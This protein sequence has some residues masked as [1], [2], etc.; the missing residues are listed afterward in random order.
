MD[1]LQYIRACIV[2]GQRRERRNTRASVNTACPSGVELIARVADARRAG[3]MGRAGRRNNTACCS[4]VG[5]IRVVTSASYRT[6]RIGR[7]GRRNIICI[8]N[9]WCS[10]IRRWKSNITPIGVGTLPLR[11]ANLRNDRTRHLS[12]PIAASRSRGCS[13][14]IKTKST[15]RYKVSI[16]LSN[17]A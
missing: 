8:H 10:T 5:H 2:L 3:C 7:A 1:V 13:V 11:G 6:T 16:N 4:G 17:R 9:K 14:S 15:T 12:A